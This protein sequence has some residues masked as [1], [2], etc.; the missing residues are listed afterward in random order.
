MIK[1]ALLPLIRNDR[2]WKILR[3]FAVA[4]LFMNNYREKLQREKNPL[5]L[6]ISE[7]RDF[8]YLFQEKKVL[9]GPFE[10][11]KYPFFS[12]VCSMLYPKLV[13][14]Y[15]ME[16]HSYI[17][18]YCHNKYS[19]ILDIG[20][21][22][23]YYANGLAMKNPVAKVYAFDIDEGARNLCY[24]MAKANGLDHQIDIRSSCNAEDLANFNFTKRGLIISDCEGY[25]LSLFDK[26][27]IGNLKNCDVLIETHD[28][29]NINITTYLCDLFK[30]SHDITVVKSTDDIEK[31]K[32]YHFKESEKLDLA[33]R[34]QLFE[35]RRP[36]TMEWLICS[37]KSGNT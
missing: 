15:E 3:R 26:N 33:S 37:P 6:P 4:G 5:T 28:F 35:E 8:D 24:E 11:M 7:N 20:C 14:S 19:E 18:S 29:I 1:G 27:N 21:A 31:A 17:Y 32:T 30:D 36:G 9:H 13:G 34:K 23:G 10:G 12:S 25:E 2:S 22:E 16:L